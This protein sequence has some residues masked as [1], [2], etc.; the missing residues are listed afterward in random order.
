MIELMRVVND[1]EKKQQLNE[2]MVNSKKQQTQHSKLTM[3]TTDRRVIE[4]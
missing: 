2:I 4:L 1:D 3:M